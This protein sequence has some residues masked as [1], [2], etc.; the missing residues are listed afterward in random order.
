MINYTLILFLSITYSKL[1][2]MHFLK[3]SKDIFPINDLLDAT[4]L[5]LLYSI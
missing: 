2:P 3:Q 4:I 5:Y 1:P